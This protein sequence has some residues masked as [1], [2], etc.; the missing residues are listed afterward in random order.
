VEHARRL[1]GIEA[2]PHAIAAGFATGA[3]VSLSPLIGLHLVLGVA[4]ALLIRGNVL[5]SAIGTLVGNPWTFPVIWLATYHI[6]ALLLP[7]YAAG[8][9]GTDTLARIAEDLTTSI[10]NLD[11]SLL[12]TTLW[13]LWLSML[14]GSIPLGVIAWAAIYCLL[15]WLLRGR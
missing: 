11:L 14:V 7:E 2:T 8:P 6:G 5:A 13:P 3:A 12:A 4:L 15:R 9:I 1:R 10:V